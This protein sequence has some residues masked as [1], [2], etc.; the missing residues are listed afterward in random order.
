MKTEQ[1]KII[2][3]LL[4]LA[5]NHIWW[6]NLIYTNANIDN[7]IYTTWYEHLEILC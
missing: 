7:L 1:N 6:F 3:A 4:G 5:P 2:Y